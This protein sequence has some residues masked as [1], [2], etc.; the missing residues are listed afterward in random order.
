MD[1]ICAYPVRQEAK[2]MTLILYAITGI[3]I[4]CGIAAY[5]KQNPNS[6]IHR[7]ITDEQYVKENVDILK[8][9]LGDKFSSKKE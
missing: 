8:K 2:I 7:V 5:V 9:R 4:G 6:D 1:R 3:A